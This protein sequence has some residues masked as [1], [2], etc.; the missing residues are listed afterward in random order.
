MIPLPKTASPFTPAAGSN[1]G[2]EAPFLPEVASSTL[3]RLYL[4]QGHVDKARALAR[5][6][7]EQNPQDGQA[8]ALLTRCQQD[9][10]CTLHSRVHDGSLFLRW[11]LK[12]APADQGAFVHIHL[13][14]ASAS[15]AAP[16][17]R[18]IRCDKLKDKR[19]IP[20]NLTQGACVAYLGQDDLTGRRPRIL[21][22]GPVH[23]WRHNKELCRI[24]I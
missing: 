18:R 6:W 12:V 16:E 14:D 3:I 13:F 10:S 8:L 9:L 5:R 21:A 11:E 17:L 15:R 7:S 23:R 24:R 19:A 22:V 4:A 2:S 1:Q 20:L